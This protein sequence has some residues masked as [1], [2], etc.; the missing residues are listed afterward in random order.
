MSELANSLIRTASILRHL[1]DD[2]NLDRI[3][4][5]VTATEWDELKEFCDGF[6]PSDERLPKGVSILKVLDI[7]VRRR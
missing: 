1:P 4:F 7:E 3:A 6:T 2:A 5:L